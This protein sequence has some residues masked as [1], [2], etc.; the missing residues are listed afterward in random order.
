MQYIH[1]YKSVCKYKTKR[2]VNTGYMY[3]LHLIKYE[4]KDCCVDF[5][6][7]DDMIFIICFED[8]YHK[9]FIKTCLICKKFT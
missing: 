1:I 6:I 8:F 3:I 2:F 4:F 9:F 5:S 7:Y